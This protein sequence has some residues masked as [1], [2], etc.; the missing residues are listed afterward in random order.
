MLMTAVNGKVASERS[1]SYGPIDQ[2]VTWFRH[3]NFMF[4][5]VKDAIAHAAL[6]IVWSNEVFV[7]DSALLGLCKNVRSEDMFHWF[8]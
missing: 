3:N 7:F 8:D 6:A 1:P 5:K 4:R 2:N